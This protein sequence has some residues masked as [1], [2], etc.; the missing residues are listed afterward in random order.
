MK[1]RNSPGSPYLG[2]TMADASQTKESPPLRGFARFNFQRASIPFQTRC[3]VNTRTM[4]LKR[5]LSIIKPGFHDKFEI[6]LP[7]NFLK[8]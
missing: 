1:H 7:D 2:N 8:H 4:S 5:R 6:P 3:A